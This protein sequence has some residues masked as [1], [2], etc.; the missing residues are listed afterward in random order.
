VHSRT[1]INFNSAY[2]KLTAPGTPDI[3]TSLTHFDGEQD[4]YLSP[5]LFAFV[6]AVL[7]HSFSQ[8]LRLQQNY[9]GGIGFVL[10]KDAAQE[11]DVKASMN[12][13]DQDFEAAPR[14]HLIGSVF[15]ET[16]NRKFVHGILFTEQGSFTPSWNNTKAYTAIGSAALTFPVYHRFGLTVGALDNFLNNPPT[17]FK[18]NSFQLTLGATYSF[19]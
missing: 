18:K 19:Q 8:G 17:G 16:Y 5:R 14:Q 4:W 10:F 6:E 9:G 12:Y 11:L 1:T 7:D 15:G 3:K 13:I 2:T